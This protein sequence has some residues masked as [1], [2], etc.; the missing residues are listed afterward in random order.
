MSELVRFGVSMDEKLLKE[1]DRYV[2][3]K[4]YPTRSKAIGDLVRK[5]LVNK[6]WAG[7]GL[8]AGAITLVYDHH[9]RELVNHLMNIQ[10]DYH[11]LIVSTQHVHMD[12]HNCLEIIVVKGKSGEVEKLADRLKAVKGVK[13]GSLSISGTTK[14]ERVLNI[15]P[16]TPSSGLYTPR[17]SSA[18]DSPH[19][20]RIVS[21]WETLS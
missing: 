16:I 10:H 8:V 12:H 14:G 5:E 19:D 18:D 17:I 2:K 11:R 20:A 7:G 15:W 21:F 3:D 1:F 4:S 13:H 6:E 9:G